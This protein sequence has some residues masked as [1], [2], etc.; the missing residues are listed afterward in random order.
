MVGNKTGYNTDID[1]I[2]SGSNS[3][4]LPEEREVI[5]IMDDRDRKWK[6]SC[7]SPTYMR[8]FENKAGFV[9]V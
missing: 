2:G 1:I 5:L 4:L 8:K 6:A 9:Q 7:S 3:K